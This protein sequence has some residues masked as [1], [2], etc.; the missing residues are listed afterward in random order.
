MRRLV[1]SLLVL[2]VG[3]TCSTTALA[4]SKS[5][6]VKDNFFSSKSLRVKRGDTVTWRWAG[7]SPHNVVVKSGPVRFA[8][9]VQRNGSYKRRITRGGTYSIVCTL[10]PGMT[11]TLKAR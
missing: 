8:S 9:K 5:V 1:T 10:H 7:S 4:A 3:A 11:M 2:A 6:Q